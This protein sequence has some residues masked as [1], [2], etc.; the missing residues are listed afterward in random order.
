MISWKAALKC[1]HFWDSQSQRNL[2]ILLETIRWKI[3]CVAAE[4]PP[5]FQPFFLVKSAILKVKLV[6]KKDSPHS[7][8]F[9]SIIIGGGTPH[10][11]PIDIAAQHIPLATQYISRQCSINHKTIRIIGDLLR[12]KRHQDPEISW[13]RGSPKFSISNDGIFPNKIIQLWG[14]PQFRTHQICKSLEIP[15]S[16]GSHLRPCRGWRATSTIPPNQAATAV[17]NPWLGRYF[18]GSH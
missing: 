17:G 6:W 14:Y 1:P 9:W 16:H 5:W 7:A 15:E 8:G 12:K 10:F 3:R 18:R 13:N 11:Q 4:K 2:Q